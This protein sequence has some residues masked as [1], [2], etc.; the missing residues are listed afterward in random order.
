MPIERHGTEV[1]TLSDVSDVTVVSRGSGANHE[2]GRP[3]VLIPFDRCE[4]IT[5]HVAANI[6]GRAERTIR[7]WCEAYH[8]G[9]R[10]GG[11]P[12]TVSRVALQM[13]LDDDEAA[14][15]AYLRGD[16][17][18]PGVVSYYDRVGLSRLIRE[19]SEKGCVVA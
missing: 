7:D 15:A 17:S 6:A 4:A 9:R 2:P 14:L 10:I 5:V 19:W 1:P 12:W 18:S 16:R 3:R 11:A 8:L 13:F